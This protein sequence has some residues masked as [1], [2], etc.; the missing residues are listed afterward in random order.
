MHFRWL[1]IFLLL[2]PAGLSAQ[3]VHNI[4]DPPFKQGIAAEVEDT[5]ITFEE[6]RREMAPLIPRIR[7]QARSREE[8][9][10]EMGRLYFEVL[11]NLVD[12]VIIVKE[13]ADKEFQIP[14][15]FIE[16]EFDRVLIEDFDNDRASFLEFLESQGKTVREFRRDLQERIIVSVMRGEMR[17]SQSQ[18]SP[19]RIQSFYDENQLRFYEEEAVKL[20][21]IMLRPVADEG[22]D[23]M[24]QSL[25]R[26]QQE[27]ADGTPFEEVARRFSQDTRRERGGDWGWI[28]RPDLKDELAE[29]AF[30]LE[31]GTYSEPIALGDQQFI[32]FVE[33]FRPE[34]IQPLSEVRDT[35]EEILVSQL[36][37]QAQTAWIERLRRD[38]YVRYY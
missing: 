16:D 37:R 7:E 17:K 33:D 20:R 13:F 6:L 4:W 34:G 10:R 2:V 11:Q 26:V 14:Q 38:A 29:V 15:T 31:T 8:F 28:Q 21:I 25:E 36:E 5:I 1:A 24:R 19:E 30:D 23:Q 9:Q 22:P 18:M 27:L 12:R 3:Q 32:L 35:I